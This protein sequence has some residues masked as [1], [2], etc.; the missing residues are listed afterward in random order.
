MISMQALH[1][2]KQFNFPSGY[3][4]SVPIRIRIGT[5][6]LRNLWVE[7]IGIGFYTILSEM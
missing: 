6:F 3:E 2:N 7:A 1:T 4:R 5:G